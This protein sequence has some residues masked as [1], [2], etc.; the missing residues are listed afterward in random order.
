MQ[1]TNTAWSEALA[2][3]RS[4]EVLGARID[5]IADDL[6]LDLGAL[7]ARLS[8]AGSQ[9][10]D[11][12]FAD[13]DWTPHT[14]GQWLFGALLATRLPSWVRQDVREEG[15]LEIAA[16]RV[17][18]G[19]LHVTGNLETKAELFVLGDLT[20][21]GFARDTYMDIA[22]VIVAGHLTCGTGVF[23]EGALMVGG[24]VAA[25]LVALTFNQG[26]AKILHG[27]SARALLEADHG[28]SRIFGPLDVPVVLS[29]ELVTDDGP[30]VSADLDAL[31]KLLTPDAAAAIAGLEPMD[32]A[33]KLADMLAEGQRLFP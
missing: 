8:A 17:V 28:G 18:L 33:S 19:N 13:G 5:E 10:F 25:P 3:L 14:P 1:A 20:V 21:D 31:A 2:A 23:S 27:V 29:D 4:D 15:D 26:F 24:R 12:L 6:G 30:P 22:H 9:T 32:A 16:R 7:A 11:A